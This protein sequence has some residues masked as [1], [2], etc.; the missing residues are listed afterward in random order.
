VIR[1]GGKRFG[2]LGRDF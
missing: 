2:A 1:E